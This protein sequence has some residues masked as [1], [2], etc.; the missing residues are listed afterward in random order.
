MEDDRPYIVESPTRIRL[1]PEAKF[2]AEQHGMSL[3]QM[4]RYLLQAEKL[5][6]DGTDVVELFD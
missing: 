3:E 2:W 4:A 1:K 6:A 5:R